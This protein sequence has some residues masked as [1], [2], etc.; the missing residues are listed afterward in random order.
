[1]VPCFLDEILELFG[2]SLLEAFGEPVVGRE[3]LADGEGGGTLLIL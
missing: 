3:V 1:M 2:Q